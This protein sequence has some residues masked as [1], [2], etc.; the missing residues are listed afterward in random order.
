MLNCFLLCTSHHQDAEEKV[1][2]NFE[3]VERLVTR[4]EDLEDQAAVDIKSYKE[5]LLRMFE[6]SFTSDCLICL[7]NTRC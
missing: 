6:V 3:I 4:P 2:L 1:E 7:S 5:K